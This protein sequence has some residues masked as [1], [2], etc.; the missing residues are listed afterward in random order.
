MTNSH[1]IVNGCKVCAVYMEIFLCVLLLFGCR[2]Q[3]INRNLLRADALMDFNPDSA[4]HVLSVISPALISTDENRALYGLLYNEARFKLYKKAD[5]RPIAFSIKY[6]SAHSDLLMLQ[7]SYYYHGAINKDNGGPLNITLDDYKNAERLINVNSES[8]LMLRI[9]EGLMDINLI[10]WNPSVALHYAKLE[11]EAAK[12][13]KDMDAVVGAINNVSVS[14]LQNDMKDSSFH[15]MKLAL[16]YCNKKIADAT[17]AKIYNNAALYYEDYYGRYDLAECYFKIAQQYAKSEST[18]FALSDIYLK[19]GRAEDAFLIL[20]NLMKSN[21]ALVRIE[22]NK[23]LGN[24]YRD[25][26]DYR[27]AYIYQTRGDSLQLNQQDEIQETEVKEIQA[28]YDAGILQSENDKFVG[29]I[30]IVS[31]S[32]LSAA[33]SVILFIIYKIRRKER[34]ISMLKL[35]IEASDKKIKQI[36]EDTNKT[37]GEKFSELKCLIVQKQ[38]LIDRLERKVNDTSAE[39]DDYMKTI[40]EI[41]DGLQWLFYVMN[42]EENLQMDKNEMLKFINCYR[43]LDDAFLANV[44]AMNGSAVTVSEEVLCILYRIG[45]SR[46][47]ICGMLNLSNEAYRQLKYRTM[48]KLKTEPSL[49]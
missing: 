43:L 1:N 44:E 7:R 24:Y 12:R 13:V 15:Y 9:Y 21:D 23:M 38:S 42:N 17:K 36:Q 20:R 35:Q 49:A 22:A 40:S 3:N 47:E 32:V 2:Q 46:N 39:N 28:K 19:T 10:H 33:L 41:T 26:G 31:L 48:K 4:Y 5:F 6:F 25:N 18:D 30:I 11:Y 14:Y 16:G 34:F 45:K 27:N 29:N 8:T 37:F